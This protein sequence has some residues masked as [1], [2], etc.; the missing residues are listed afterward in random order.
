MSWHLWVRRGTHAHDHIIHRYRFLQYIIRSVQYEAGTNK[1]KI[2]GSSSSELLYLHAHFRK[3]KP[4][5]IALMGGDLHLFWLDHLPFRCAFLLSSFL[6]RLVLA[7]LPFLARHRFLHLWGRWH[8]LRLRPFRIRVNA[9]YTV[10]TYSKYVTI[11]SNPN[12]LVKLC[13]K[14]SAQWAQGPDGLCWALGRMSQIG[15]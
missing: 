3:A 10:H 5:P 15:F 13:W 4:L 1:L 11:A 6:P 12:I 8:R 14:D 9:I 7:L 2:K